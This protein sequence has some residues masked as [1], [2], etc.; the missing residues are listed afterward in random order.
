MQHPILDAIEKSQMKEGVPALR[1]GDQVQISKTIVEGKKKR[2]QK[3]EG[4]IVKMHGHMSRSS[5]TLRRVVEGVG[6]EQS[7][8]MH[9]PLVSEIK[10][11][12]KGKARR[13]RLTYLRERVGS[14]AVRMKDRE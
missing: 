12:K 3:F 1:V 14:K 4:T 8:L 6:V 13:A 10:L 2:T 9:S 7:F 5:L 11:I